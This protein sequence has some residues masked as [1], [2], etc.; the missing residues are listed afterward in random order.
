LVAAVVLPIDGT[1]EARMK[2]R[3]RHMLAL[4]DANDITTDQHSAAGAALFERLSRSIDLGEFHD[5]LDDLIDGL[6]RI[7]ET[8]EPDEW[9]ALAE[10]ARANRRLDDL[11]HQDPLTRCAFEKPRGY[12]GD[13]VMMDYAY[14][15]HG[16]H[17]ACAR[18]TPF[19]R[20]LLRHI[21][22]RP[23][24]QGVRHRRACIAQLIDET[25]AETP[26]PSILA[27]ASRH[28]REAE[29]STALASGRI[30]RYVALDADA[31]SLGEVVAQY[32]RF[33]VETVHASVR[34]LLARKVAL[35]TFD[36]VYA[37][38]LYDYLNG[39]TATALTARL[40]EL[41]A[42]G[43]RLLIP[44]FAPCC[45]DR[46]YMESFMAWD[47]IY[48]DEFDMTELVAQIPVDEME[49]YDLFSGPSSSIVYLLIR[50]T[51]AVPQS[52]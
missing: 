21:Q 22:N 49:S 36:F 40:F 13:A 25:A 23:A 8:S 46:A 51:K 11:L 4:S 26:H 28:L 7:R 6:E 39:A 16:A 9:Q 29:L 37:A 18:A 41:T 30:R 35:G 12:A 34:H 42:P 24:V 15:I 17:E 19:G 27:V 45:P 44:N 33:G 31:E 10:H 43:G 52:N 5:R 2:G 20:A 32:A 1:D 50:K 14:G 48:R 38:G 47:L 3:G